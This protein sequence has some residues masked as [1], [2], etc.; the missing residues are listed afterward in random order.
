MWP[1]STTATPEEPC[2][3]ATKPSTPTVSHQEPRPSY[4]CILDECLQK[5]GAMEPFRALFDPSIFGTDA[6]ELET[7]D[8]TSSTESLPIPC[9]PGSEGF[10]FQDIYTSTTMQ[11]F[12]P[13][14][15]VLKK[16]HHNLV[17]ITTP[18]QR[19]EFSLT[20]PDLCLSG[21][22]AW[23]SFCTSFP[24][25][26][27]WE[28]IERG[29]YADREYSRMSDPHSPCHL[30]I[31]TPGSDSMILFRKMFDDQCRGIK[32]SDLYGLVANISSMN[33]NGCTSPSLS[34]VSVENCSSLSSSLTSSRRS[35]WATSISTSHDGENDQ[36]SAYFHTKFDLESV[37]TEDD[38]DLLKDF[39]HYHK[40]IDKG[41]PQNYH[42]RCI[43]AERT[44]QL[45]NEDVLTPET[46]ESISANFAHVAGRDVV[47]DGQ[48]ASV[49]KAV[50]HIE[51]KHTQPNNAPAFN[52]HGTATPSS[53][54]AEAA[55][56]AHSYCHA[57]PEFAK[58][59]LLT[60]DGGREYVL[61]RDCFH[62]VPIELAPEFVRAVEADE[63]GCG[64]MCDDVIGGT[65]LGTIP[66]EE[67]EG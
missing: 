51:A 36:K 5:Y 10:S 2:D 30:N 47:S 19:Q 1:A 13:P 59:K 64:T 20:L 38:L 32:D 15:P 60:D 34:S 66:E 48:K 58:L 7:T 8:T 16:S 52:S 12:L 37:R 29:E 27:L 11:H 57:D 40:L 33:I 26:F 4:L 56:W 50:C 6:D 49:I 46:A 25:E 9:S 24:D 61:Y 17:H 39:Q 63:Y 62:C 22:G 44:S 65:T 28:G 31:H 21:S 45:G 18:A 54:P 53:P 23:A 42:N 55:A 3:L 35:S 41:T 14:V 67:N 43:G